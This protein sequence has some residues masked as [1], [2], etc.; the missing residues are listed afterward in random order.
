[1]N[2]KQFLHLLIGLFIILVGVYLAYRWDEEFLIFIKG[3]IP[4]VVVVIGILWALIGY[5]LAEDIE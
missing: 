3:A 4:V 5:L 1:M 2:I